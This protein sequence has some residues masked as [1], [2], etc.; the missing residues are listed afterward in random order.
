MRKHMM[1]DV[2]ACYWVFEP[3][4]RQQKSLMVSPWTCDSFCWFQSTIVFT[5]KNS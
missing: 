1:G 5:K 3:Q 2:C 4:I